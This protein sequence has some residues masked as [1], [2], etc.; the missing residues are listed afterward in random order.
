[1]DLG[2]V[3]CTYC[4]TVHSC[5]GLEDESPFKLTSTLAVLGGSQYFNAK[6][7]YGAELTCADGDT[8]DT[9]FLFSP[10]LLELRMCFLISKNVKVKREVNMFKDVLFFFF[11]AF[12]A[13]CISTVLAFG[14]ILWSFI[15]V[16]ALCPSVRTTQTVN[17]L[18]NCRLLN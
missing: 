14:P 13:H 15:P 12:G 5:P 2:N 11:Y 3:I 10:H 16:H 6:H 8:Q 17:S 18:Y 4:V 7:L 9:A 1:M